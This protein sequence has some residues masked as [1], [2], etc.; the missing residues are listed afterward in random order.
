MTIF[1]LKIF[2]LFA[3]VNFDCFT[4]NFYNENGGEVTKNVSRSLKKT[5]VPAL[6]GKI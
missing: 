4:N 6:T 2:I 1:F 5:D 3:G